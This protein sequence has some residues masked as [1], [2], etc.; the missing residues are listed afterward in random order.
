MPDHAEKHGG[1]LGEKKKAE[2]Q[3]HDPAEEPVSGLTPHFNSLRVVH[4]VTS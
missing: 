2:T 4:G 3:D 1:D